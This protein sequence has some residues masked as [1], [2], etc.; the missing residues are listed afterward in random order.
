MFLGFV[1]GGSGKVSEWVISFLFLLLVGLFLTDFP[2]IEV[3]DSHIKLADS[4]DLSG[5]SDDMSIDL[6]GEVEFDV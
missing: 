4:V 3:I 1:I 2:E 6:V 5:H